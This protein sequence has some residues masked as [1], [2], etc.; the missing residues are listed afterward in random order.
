MHGT[1]LQHTLS[2]CISRNAAC[3]LA[4][5]GPN[6]HTPIKMIFSPL[7]VEFG[8]VALPRDLVL[9]V[10]CLYAGP[11]IVPSPFSCCVPCAPS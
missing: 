5:K 9:V 3:F 6:S 8:E 1:R 10:D 7:L 4:R 11:S 2:G